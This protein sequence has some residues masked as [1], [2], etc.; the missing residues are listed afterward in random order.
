MRVPSTLMTM[1]KISHMCIA[2]V[3]FIFASCSSSLLVNGTEDGNIA[4]EYSAVCG[5]ELMTAITSIAGSGDGALFDSAKIRDA[6]TLAKLAKIK[7]SVPK[8]DRLYLAAELSKNAE[9]SVSKSKIAENNAQNG[10]TLTLSP[11]TL[12]ALYAELPTDFQSYIDLF[13]APVFTG[14]DMSDTDYLDLLSAVYGKA[15]ANEFGNAVLSI[16]LQNGAAKQ[17]HKVRLI[18]LLNLKEPFVL[19]LPKIAG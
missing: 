15:L 12:Q 2:G 13:M 5:K 10:V 14:E 7:V 16:T 11:Q 8:N 6:L 9:D 4:F 19:R 17:A 3:V 18:K 1:K